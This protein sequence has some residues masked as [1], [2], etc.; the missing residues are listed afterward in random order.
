MQIASRLL[1]CVVG[2]RR[3]GTSHARK[4]IARLRNALRVPFMV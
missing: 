2:F 1:G 4:R 3:S